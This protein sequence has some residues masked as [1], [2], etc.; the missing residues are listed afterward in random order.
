MTISVGILAFDHVEELDL[1]GPWE[2][3]QSAN[4]LNGSFQAELVSF[5]G[6]MVM[7]SKGMQIGVH[8]AMQLRHYD[9]LIHPGGK[10]VRSC[11]SNPAYMEMY[12]KMAAEATWICSVCTGALVLAHANLLIGKDCTTYYAT[13][14]ELEKTR[15]TGRVI[16]NQR[17]VRDGNVL[18]SAGVSAGIDMSLWL[19][20]ELTTPPFAREVQQYIEYFPEPPYGN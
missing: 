8:Q 3:F 4:L 1:V 15:K 10:G 13:C 12:K 5:D 20:G 11:I 9:I 16:R 17:Y 14:D 6:N 19:I 2:I 7:A 18:S